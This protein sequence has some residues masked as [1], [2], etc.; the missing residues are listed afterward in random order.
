[1]ADSLRDHAR[2]A[3]EPTGTS[4]RGMDADTLFRAAMHTTSDFPNL[5]SS[6]GNRTLIGA[7]QAA[8]SPIRPPWP[9][10]RRCPTFGLAPA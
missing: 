6:T 5:L 7:Y 4:T 10:K 9:G 2:A 1:M 3:V 8:Q